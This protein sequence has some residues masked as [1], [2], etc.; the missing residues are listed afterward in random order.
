MSGR[1]E[2]EPCP[3]CSQSAC[4]LTD[5]T[6]SGLGHS[7]F[8]YTAQWY[9]CQRCGLVYVRNITDTVLAQYYAGECSY[10][11]NAHFS[12]TAPENLEKYAV[13][14]AVLKE[15]AVGPVPMADVGCGRGGFVNW[16]SESGWEA[17]CTGVDVDVRSLEQGL[18]KCGNVT[19]RVGDAV[20]LPV[21]DNSMGLLTY[22][23][24]LEHVRDLRGLL[25]ES[26]RV[27]ELG[28]HLLI[29]VPDAE[30]YGELPIGTGF[31]ASIREHIF[32][33]TARALM[34]AL[35][36]YGFEV[37]TVLRRTMPTPELSY[38][39]LMV[40]ARKTGHTPTAEPVPLVGNVAEYV[41][42]SKEALGRQARDIQS[43]AENQPITIWG[44]SSALFS[45][46]PLVESGPFRLCDGSKLK[47]TT[48]YCG[49]PI[50]DPASVPVSGALIIAPYLHGNAIHAEAN[51]L[52]WPASTV[53]R[54]H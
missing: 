16:L 35:S 1:K 13:Y 25:R 22:F 9:T 52:G 27:L 26:A 14:G 2:Q 30:C 50:E 19:F 48:H 24:V 15:H 20:R 8:N 17:S 4:A 34:A 10:F 38:P 54:L 40:L 29:E 44:C 11:D 36:A 37:R 41:L 5:W 51:R 53:H 3:A 45:V 28:G 32:H 18:S 12:V 43:M 21:D 31:W 23:H 49:R 33:Y 46:L 6:F 42:D 39:S 47:Q 7:I